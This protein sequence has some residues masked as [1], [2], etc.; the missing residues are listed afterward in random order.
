MSL[1]IMLAAIA[2][3]MGIIF[4]FYSNY[5]IYNYVFFIREAL[6][7]TT[8]YFAFLFGVLVP[9]VGIALVFMGGKKDNALKIWSGFAVVSGLT[10]L[11]YGM[12][13]TRDLVM[14]YYKIM[15]G[16]VLARAGMRQGGVGGSVMA[17]VGMATSMVLNPMITQ[18]A[19]R[20]LPYPLNWAVWCAVRPYVPMSI[21]GIIPA[22]CIW[23]CVPVMLALASI[24]KAGGDGTEFVPASRIK[25]FYKLSESKR[26]RVRDGSD[27][28]GGDTDSSNDVTSSSESGDS[29]YGQDI[30]A[31]SAPALT[32]SDS[33]AP[34]EHRSKKRA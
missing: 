21:L 3:T 7:G 11:I 33:D 6:I 16:S 17:G 4:Y 5:Y 10:W 28:E 12:M 29:R 14:N 19:E 20:S 2:T 25:W 13:F 31:P 24:V 23:Q 22:I 34:K 15:P 32:N 1:L 27:L 26:Q 18:M 9:I 30:E 8:A